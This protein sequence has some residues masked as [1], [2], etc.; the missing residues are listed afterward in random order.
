MKPIE[1]EVHQ[2]IAKTITP[3][4]ALAVRLASSP[5]RLYLAVYEEHDDHGCDLEAQGEALGE[6]LRPLLSERAKTALLKTL[7]AE[8][9]R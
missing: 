4:E 6:L 7:H 8:R 5:T 3:K 9:Q 1:I 2:I